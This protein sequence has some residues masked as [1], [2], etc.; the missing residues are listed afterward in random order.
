MSM[1]L[2]TTSL[3][4]LVASACALEGPT[5]SFDTVFATGNGD[6]SCPDWMCGSN[7]PKI[8]NHG[9]WELNVAGMPTPAGFYL[10]R[11]TRDGHDYSVIVKNAELIATRLSDGATLSGSAVVGL[12]LWIHNTYDASMIYEVQV[13]DANRKVT[14]WAQHPDSERQTQSYTLGWRVPPPSP[15]FSPPFENICD[16]DED[17]ASYA[18]LFEGDRVDATRMT[19][20]GPELDWFNIG[21]AGHA[22]AKLHLSG[23]SYGARGAGF[24][25]SAGE[26]TTMLKLLGAD[27]CGTG[28]SFTEAGVPLMWRD[29]RNWME[30]SAFA[31]LEA[32]WTDQGVT[33]L[34]TPRLVANGSITARSMDERLVEACKARPPRCSDSKS[35]S[36]PA[37]THLESANPAFP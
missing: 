25:T 19:V 27:Y 35:T 31:S 13:L 32:R 26:R 8:A 36:P 17:G 24:V 5:E 6:T 16:P 7:S 2:A 12:S 33:C 23:H 29:D 20:G 10:H 34:N 30:F 28:T 4:L 37:G 18:V 21:C 14:Y 1:R 11:A 3:S 22:L 15:T 9:V